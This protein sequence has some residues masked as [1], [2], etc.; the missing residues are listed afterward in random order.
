MSNYSILENNTLYGFSEP[1]QNLYLKLLD[2]HQGRTKG[3]EM[4]AF[5]EADRFE[6][7]I[8]RDLGKALLKAPHPAGVKVRKEVG[9]FIADRWRHGQ[10]GAA[11][12]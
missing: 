3:G 1:T 12:S 7:S 10:K 9:E 11:I 2:T 8:G 4:R 6:R 5:L